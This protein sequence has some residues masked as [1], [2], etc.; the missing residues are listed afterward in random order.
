MIIFTGSTLE[1]ARC[2]ILYAT[3][4]ILLRNFL[5]RKKSLIR[6]FSCLTRASHVGFFLLRSG[7]YMLPSLFWFLLGKWPRDDFCRVRSPEMLC[8]ICFSPTRFTYTTAS[9][10]GLLCQRA[11]LGDLEPSASHNF[12]WPDHGSP[13]TL[14][15]MY[16]STNFKLVPAMPSDVTCEKWIHRWLTWKAYTTVATVL[17][18]AI[19]WARKPK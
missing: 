2:Y 6:E 14:W 9:I 1:P 15:Q 7:G 12:I 17:K 11:P 16:L 10:L 4:T 19:R 8:W 18:S 3:Y 13:G 5:F